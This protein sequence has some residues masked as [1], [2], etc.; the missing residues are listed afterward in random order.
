MTNTPSLWS[1]PPPF[2]SLP[3][4]NPRRPKVQAPEDNIIVY[5]VLTP[6]KIHAQVFEAK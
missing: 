4:K 2:P 6:R 3:R 5:M 1:S